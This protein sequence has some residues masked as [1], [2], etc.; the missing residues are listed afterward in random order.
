[1]AFHSNTTQCVF[2]QTNA[3]PTEP[4][5]ATCSTCQRQIVHCP[6]CNTKNRP[7][8]R[9]CRNCR[10]PI[11]S[12]GLWGMMAGNACRTSVCECSSLSSPSLDAP[13]EYERSPLPHPHNEAEIQHFYPQPV[14]TDEILVL[15]AHDRH[16]RQE[17][18]LCAVDPHTG[19]H[20]FSVPHA[21]ENRLS[22]SL[23]SNGVDLWARTHHQLV[24]YSLLYGLSLRSQIALPP[25]SAPHAAPLWLSPSPTD[26]HHGL[27][28]ILSQHTISCF[29]RDLRQITSIPLEWDPNT[30]LSDYRSLCGFWPYL[31]AVSAKGDFLCIKFLDLDGGYQ[32]IQQGKLPNTSGSKTPLYA[33]PVFADDQFWIEW[34]CPTTTPPDH[35][36]RRLQKTSETGLIAMHPEKPPLSYPTERNL[37]FDSVDLALSFRYPPLYDSSSKRLLLYSGH[38]PGRATLHFFHTLN[39]HTT[40]LQTSL[41]TLHRYRSIPLPHALWFAKGSHELCAL[42]LATGH[43]QTHHVAH[44]LAQKKI[45]GTPIYK[46]NRILLPMQDRYMCIRMPDQQPNTKRFHSEEPRP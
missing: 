26:P 11:E 35:S 34:L 5:N 37:L 9:F 2:F 32:I 40:Q 29:H 13:W 27:L 22:H 33:A 3:C 17:P 25:Q 28:C 31:L 8:A 39:Q 41:E 30:D 38:H 45:E 20:L 1:M 24:H 43:H 18:H 14:W 12:F 7:I 16:Q 19:R 4:A 6:H 42:S 44:E 21:W 46:S 10:T 23:T 36:A 15:H